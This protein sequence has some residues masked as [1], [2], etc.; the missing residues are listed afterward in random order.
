M[1]KKLLILLTTLLALVLTIGAGPEHGSTLYFEPLTASGTP[2]SEPACAPFKLPAGFYQH[3]LVEE[4]GVCGEG[5]TFDVYDVDGAVNALGDVVDLN[6][7]NVT[8]ETNPY[9]FLRGK[10]MYRTHEHGSNGAI[11]VVSLKTGEVRLLATD[12]SWCRFDGIEWTPWGTLLAAEECGA[13][14]R[15]FEFII[16]PYNPMELLEIH[17]RPAVG[18]M[19][20]EGVVVD[21][22]GNIYVVDELNG[23]SIYKFVPNSWGD[24]SSGTLYAL[25]I[26]DEDAAPGN[27]TGTAEWLALV[28][29]QNGVITDPSINARAAA[30]EAGATDYFR[31]E[32]AEIIGDTIYV[33][34]TT[35]NQVY[36]FNATG[37]PFVTEF[38]G[39]GVNINA[40]SDVPEYGLSSPDN[41]AKDALG[42]LYIVEDNSGKSD[43]W[44]ATPDLDGDGHA[45]QVVL[46]ATLTTPGAEAT[47]IYFNLPRDPYTLYV[48]VQHADDGND[49]TIAIDK[50]SSWLPR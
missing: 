26:V 32:D 12:P 48:N 38:V 5:T 27:G 29:G 8:N 35:T 37:A 23:G 41:L 7:M 16:N 4:D 13:G 30:D 14:G 43:I 34:T 39:V 21:N 28:P 20:H 3:I 2:G 22:Q 44:V 1:L 47:G 46:A 9:F 49:M 45:D 10:Y 15:L 50:N 19:S 6:D 18:R 25:N 24:L 42:N 36:A 33:A 31:P 40:E 17:D 11:S